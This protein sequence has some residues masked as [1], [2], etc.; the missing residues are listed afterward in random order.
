MAQLGIRT[1]DD[2]IGRSD[3]LDTRRASSTGRP[4]G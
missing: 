1:F 2:L 3:L 4:A